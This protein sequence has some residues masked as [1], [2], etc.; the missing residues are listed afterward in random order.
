MSFNNL[1]LAANCANNVGQHAGTVCAEHNMLRQH[2]GRR[3]MLANIF[4]HVQKCWPTSSQHNVR[5]H[6]LRHLQHVGQHVGENV[7]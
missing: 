6:G 7:G 1:K 4:E 2:V 5:W 3:K